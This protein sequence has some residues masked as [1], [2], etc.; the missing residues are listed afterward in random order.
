MQR[1]LSPWGRA[2]VVLPSLSL[3]TALLDGKDSVGK[4]PAKQM[5]Y[6]TKRTATLLMERLGFRVKY[7]TE[8]FNSSTIVLLAEKQP[9]LEFDQIPRWVGVP[10]GDVWVIEPL[11]PFDGVHREAA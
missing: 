7:V 4:V 5:W 9:H 11:V 8:S 10:T 3:V 1:I 6:Y 2:L